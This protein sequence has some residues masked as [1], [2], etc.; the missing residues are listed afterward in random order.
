MPASIASAMPRCVAGPGRC[1]SGSSRR[2]SSWRRGPGSGAPLTTMSERRAVRV[3]GGVERHRAEADLAPPRVQLGVRRTAAPPRA[4]RAAARR[5]RAATT[6]R[7]RARRAAAPPC[8]PPDAR[9]RSVG[10]RRCAADPAPAPTPVTRSTSTCTSTRPS[11]SATVDQRPHRG[12]PR[13]VPPLQADR[14]PD[15]GGHQR[16]APVPA[17]VAGHLADGVVAGAGWRRAGRRAARASARP[18]R[19][20]A[21]KSTASSLSPSTSTSATSKR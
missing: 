15:A 19:Y 3:G 10:R 21:A 9:P 7:G 13:R 16:R 11:P 6:A 12:E 17:E 1:G 4:G 18:R 2:G 14:P 20:W 8:R 5:G